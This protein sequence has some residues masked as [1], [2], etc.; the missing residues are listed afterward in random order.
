M[1]AVVFECAAVEGAEGA[2]GIGIEVVE[3][4]LVGEEFGGEFDGGVVGILI[5]EPFAVGGVE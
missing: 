5:A 2:E 4:D 1:A 3:I